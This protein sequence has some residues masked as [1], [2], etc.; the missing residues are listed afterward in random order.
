M[1]W[2]SIEK[3]LIRVAFCFIMWFFP[4]RKQIKK[5]LEKIRDSF[6]K[7]DELIGSQ[8]KAIKEIKKEIISKKE[9]ELMIKEAVLDLKVQFGSMSEPKSEP[10]QKKAIKQFERVIYQRARNL[11]PEAI[12]QAIR[13][14]LAKGLTTTDI[15]RELVV[16]KNLCGKTQFYHYLSLVR[17]ESPELVRTE[18]N[19][20][21]FQA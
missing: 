21:S 7:R 18:P 15:Y 20:T 17:S 16:N 9:V 2:V 13:G 5:E 10:K 3:F 14:L 6:K 1:S 8:D 19:R 12:K 11:R 4:T